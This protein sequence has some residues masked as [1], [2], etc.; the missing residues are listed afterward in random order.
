MLHG[1]DVEMHRGYPIT[2]LATF[3]LMSI[4]VW[5]MCFVVD[6]YDLYPRVPGLSQEKTVDLFY[7]LRLHKPYAVERVQPQ[8]LIA[9]SSRVA[10]I[11]PQPLSALGGD[12]YN[13]ALPG[14][15]LREILHLVEH[16][17]AINPQKSVVVSVDHL[18]FRDGYSD[19][20]VADVDDRYRKVHA[21]MKDWMQY[22]YQRLVDSWRS[23]Y[24]VDALMNSLRV[25]LTIDR[26]NMEYDKDGTWNR[27]SNITPPNERY[28][29]ESKRTYD[30]EI[31]SK[32]AS[33]EFDEL[34]ALLDFTDANNID[35]V[36][37][38]PPLQGLLMQTLYLA[39]TWESYL[40][41]QRDLV[42]LVNARNTDM[43]IY[44]MED[45]PQLVLEAIGAPDPL[46][47]DGLHYTRKAGDQ[48]AACLAG[49][50]DSSLNPTRLDNRPVDSYLEQV[51][52]LREQYVEQHPAEI[53][54]LRK[55]LK[56]KP[57]NGT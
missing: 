31:E 14:A 43:K 36:L 13:A 6:P 10:N 7:A 50:C 20:M 15:T 9:G 29:S 45:N 34:T 32:N 55:L 54:K 47:H 8:V 26:S 44:G 5:I 57:G 2:A 28:F 56:I 35:V 49:P 19:Q 1:S 12:A 3:F 27:I 33:V 48:I 52:T 16:A 30:R 37:L 40:N 25:L 18:M 53:A 24:S 17:H 21:G 38:I 51:D 41:W 4:S 23:L 11:P 39:G 22:Y 42:A 46:F